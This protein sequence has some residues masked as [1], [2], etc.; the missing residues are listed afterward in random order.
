MRCKW[1]HSF[2]PGKTSE[3]RQWHCLFSKPSPPQSH[4]EGHGLPHPGDYLRLCWCTFLQQATLLQQGVKATLPNNTQKQTQGGC[5]NEETKKHGPDERIN[6][7]SRKRTKQ[8]GDK[9]ST[10]C[11][12]QNTGYQDALGPDWVLQQHKK[13]SGG[14]EGYIK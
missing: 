5:Q 1:G 10:R 11:R 2:L 9:Q 8:N 13:D 7:N 3:A 6:E 14:N 12:V 4:R